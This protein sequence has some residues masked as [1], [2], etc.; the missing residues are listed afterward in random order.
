[1]LQYIC[2]CDDTKS[3]I[4][5][6]NYVDS[7]NPPAAFSHLADTFIQRNTIYTQ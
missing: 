4:L 1:M 7:L 6:K 5:N 3:E 2:V